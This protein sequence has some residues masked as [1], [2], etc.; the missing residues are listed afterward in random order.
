MPSDWNSFRKELEEKGYLQPQKGGFFFRW[1]LKSLTPGGSLIRLALWTSLMTAGALS[2]M[3]AAL[4]L[5]TQHVFLPQIIVYYFPLLVLAS[6]VVFALLTVV[7]RLHPFRTPTRA[8]AA[9]AFLAAAGGAW[10]LISPFHF[11]L[12][13]KAQPF[14]LGAETILLALLLFPPLRALAFISFRE[15][16]LLRYRLGGWIALGFGLV[17]GAAGLL[18][19]LPNHAADEGGRFP[20]SPLEK[21]LAVFAVDALEAKS[22]PGDFPV[23]NEILANGGLIDFRV[24]GRPSPPVFWTQAATG[25]P[26]E[27]N[28]IVSLQAYHLP[29]IARALYPLPMAGLFSTLGIARES[30]ASTAERKKPAFWELASWA[31]RPSACVN[32]W[33]SWS[34]KDPGVE[35]VSNLFLIQKLRGLTGTQCQ[36]AELCRIEYSGNPTGAEGARWDELTWEAVAKTGQRKA[37]ATA[38]FPGLDVSLFQARALTLAQGLDL[39]KDLTPSLT[40]IESALADFKARGYRILLISFSGRQEKPW[41]WAAFFPVEK[42]SGAAGGATALDLLPT[43]LHTLEMPAARDLPGRV[44]P[45][46][47]ISSNEQIIPGYPGLSAARTA[48]GRTPIEELRSLGYLQ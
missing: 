24:D 33:S 9:F 32:W 38:Y 21:P 11:Y 14:L 43:I 20:L 25:F 12:P 39:S 7:L 16:N 19:F 47:W 48:A 35:V 13:A 41:A 44:L 40:A 26:P 31:G 10:A 29:F 15:P 4:F 22:I 30:L 3:L 37:L 17:L 2:L 1:S 45:T 27:V 28:G 6:F 42:A 36:P 18:F 5:I 23:L 8:A 34:P 46:P